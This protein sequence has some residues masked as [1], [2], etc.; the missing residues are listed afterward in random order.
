[1]N[2]VEKD[3]QDAVGLN[4][5]EHGVPQALSCAVCHAD[6]TTFRAGVLEQI[7]SVGRDPNG[8][9]QH[10]PGAKLD[11]GKMRASLVLGAFPRALQKVSEVGTYGA[12]KYSDNGWLEVPGALERY[13]DAMLRHWLAAKTGEDVDPET[14]IEHAAHQAWNAL[15]VLELKLRGELCS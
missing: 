6:Y 1:M 11:A 12:N 7:R 4:A 5:C 8:I 14:G 13:D 15:A 9:D 10:A 3:I 2:T